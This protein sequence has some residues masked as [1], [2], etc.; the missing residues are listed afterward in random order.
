MQVATNR[1]TRKGVEKCTEVLKFLS[2]IRDCR[3]LK[4]DV[5]EEAEKCTEV[6]KFLSSIRDFKSPE[7]ELLAWV[8]QRLQQRHLA[9]GDGRLI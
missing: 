6:L 8:L 3:V 1:C 2:S 4:I 9:H 7:I 5:F